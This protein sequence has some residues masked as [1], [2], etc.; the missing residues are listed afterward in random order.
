MKTASAERLQPSTEPK[1]ISILGSTGSIGA[2]TL[3]IVR[4]HPERF[5]VEAITGSNNIQ[6]LIQQALEFRP[7]LAVIANP[8]YYLQLK[9][10]LAGTGIETGAGETAVMEAAQRPAAWVMAG[11]VGIAGLKPTF[12]AIERGAT[13]ALANK[14]CMVTAGDILK[15]ECHRSGATL[16]PVD[17]EHN[18]IFQALGNGGLDSVEA[19]TL[20]ASGGPFLRYTKEQLAHVIPAQALAHPNW[21]MGPKITV[22]SASLMNKGLEVIE[23]WHFFPIAKEKI[24]VLVHPESIVHSLVH[25]VDGSVLAQLSMPDMATPIAYTMSYPERVKIHV[26]KLNLAS[27]AAL[28]F[29]QPDTVRFPCLRLAYEALH[30]GGA[31][32][33]VL[34][35]ANEEAVQAFLNNGLSF[36]DIPRLIEDV[37]SS[38]RLPAP[39]SL[40]DV[41][42][43]DL[44][45]R[46]AALQWSL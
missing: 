22:D 40:D 6:L 46:E 35:A 15:A 17:S 5:Q 26:P 10:A 11:I 14:E 23:A 8:D 34:N 39:S 28:H 37:L 32:P 27:V 2:T 33:A 19:I 7:R 16:L 13:V 3:S 38:L 18:A 9:D 21:K 44:R 30:A 42:A 24:G 41:M 12:A 43:I 45:A 1:R 29:E 31:T 25:Y 20:T 4:Q 36:L